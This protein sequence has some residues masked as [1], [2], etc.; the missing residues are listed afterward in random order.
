MKRS[1]FIS[2]KEALAQRSKKPWACFET[3]GPDVDGRVAFSIS[4]NK[5]FI[6]NLQDLGMGGI[7]DEETLHMF[8][9]RA[10]M[11]PE[12]MDDNTVSPAETPNLSHEA[13]QFRR[14]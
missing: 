9:I 2:L 6:K 14:G 11:I 12:Y 13:N 10:R 1:L 8:F 5:A 7:N 4:S 3:T